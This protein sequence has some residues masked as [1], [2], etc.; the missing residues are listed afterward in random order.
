[1]RPELLRALPVLCLL[2]ACQ[3]GGGKDSD[4]AGTGDDEIPP[5]IDPNRV[6]LHRLNRTEY[7]NTV[8]DLL[9][10]AQTPARDFPPDDLVGGF[11]NIASNLS[12]SPLHLELYELAARSLADEVLDVPLAERVRL[13]AEGEGALVTAT[14]GG[15]SG[16]AWNLW[17]QGDLSWRFDAPESGTYELSVRAYAQQA[18]PDTAQM[19]LGHDGF[20]DLTTDVTATTDTGAQVFTVSVELAQGPHTLVATFTNDYYDSASGA[21]RNLLVDWLEVYGPTDVEP[22]SNPLRDRWVTCDPAVDGDRECLD[23]VMSRFATAAWRRP[24]TAAELRSLG[25]VGQSI[26]DDDAGGGT[27]EDAL[28]WSFVAVLM[29]P[30]FVYRVEL[31]PDPNDPAPHLVSDYEM[32][33]RLS[34]FLWSSMPDDELLA[35]AAAGELTT[36]EGVEAQVRR[37]IR[38]DRAE[39]L[40][41]NF[42]GQWLFVRGIEAV[43]KDPNAFPEVTPELR[44]SMQEEMYRFFR[45]FVTSGRDLRE[46]VTASDGEIDEQLAMLYDIPA[47]GDGFR[48]VN[49]AEHDRGGLLGQGGLLMVESYPARTSPVIR[50]K[51]VLGQLLCDEPP[52]PPPGVEGLDEDVTASTLREQLEQHR[53]D[54]VC[55]SCHQAMDPIGFALEN[56]DAVGAWRDEDRGIS[57]D[58]TG[59]LPDGRTFDGM[60]ELGAVIHDDPMFPLCMSEKLMSYGLGRLPEESD[61]G[62]V[63]QM[64]DRFADEGWSFEG[65]VLA[66]ATN[67]TFRYRRGEP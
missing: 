5:A 18:G 9:G 63:H 7:D 53:S 62:Y 37:M 32:A 42:G 17:S 52:P 48:P 11:D 67:D 26:L 12:V 14:T 36:V 25:D 6:V 19:V 64:K 22:G 30:N 61:E 49:L 40:V 31:E 47:S 39:S 4:A 55:A 27:F 33:S 1:M 43:S 3:G 13:R 46:L 57:I 29:S 44:A 45:S 41:Q 54:P 10:T 66:V 21:D 60:R 20:V 50:G 23:D 35:A 34:Y 24:A 38:D 15:S 58:A 8:R 56:F 28:Y 65:L 2:A 51:F 16:D 59:E